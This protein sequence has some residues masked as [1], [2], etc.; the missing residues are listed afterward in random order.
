MRRR[1]GEVDH[2]PSHQR[3]RLADRHSHAADQ[4]VPVDAHAFRRR[5]DAREVEVDARRVGENAN[6]RRRQRATGREEDGRFTVP[7]VDEAHRLQ[8]R[9]GGDRQRSGSR[10]CVGAWGLGRTG[11]TSGR[12]ASLRRSE[13]CRR[14]CR[15]GGHRCG[16]RGRGSGLRRL[17]RGRPGSRRGGAGRSGRHPDNKRELPGVTPV[18]FESMRRRLGEIDHDASHQRSQLVDRHAHPT[19][20]GVAVAA[21]PV[22]RR[23]D[24]GEIEVDARRVGEDADLRRRQCAICIENDRGRAVPGDEAHGLQRRPGREKPARREDESCQ[25]NP[26]RTKVRRESGRAIH[27]RRPVGGLHGRSCPAAPSCVAGLYHR[28]TVPARNSVGRFGSEQRRARL[29]F[30]SES[31]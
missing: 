11:R 6:L 31:C 25:G 9:S 15:H 20:A 16:R 10:C 4:E 3:L 17:G 30:R 19:D 21:H 18:C 23:R 27:G 7:D 14:R 1:P 13:R 24:V 5:C 8:R 28:R 26:D 22:G 29:Y 12:L 2:D